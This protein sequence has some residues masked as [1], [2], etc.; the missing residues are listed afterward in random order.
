[1]FLADERTLETLDFFAVRDRVV[2]NTRTERGSVRAGELLPLVDFARVREEQ[3]ATAQVRQ[4]LA[5]ADFF[6]E[7]AID[8][9]VLTA[10]AQQGSALGASDLRAVADALISAMSAYRRVRENTHDVLEKVTAGFV[11]LLQL[12]NA[13][14]DAIDEGAQIL[15]RA[16][17]ALRRLR[18]D[19]VAAQNEAR[20]RVNSMLRS[21]K[22]ERA[23]QESVVTIRE[24]RFVIPIKAEFIGEVPGIVHDSSSSGQTLFVEPLDSVQTNNRLRTLR[25]EEEREVARIL[26]ELS[27]AIGDHAAQIEGNIDVLASLDVLVAKARI[28]QSMNAMAPSLLEKATLDIR[29]GTHPLL[30]QRAVPQSLLLSEEIRL[31][32]VSGPNMGGKTVALKMVGLFVCMTYAGL[33]I[34]ANSGTHIGQ[35]ARVITD[36]G[37]EQSIAQNASTFSAHLLRMAG[38]LKDADAHS[39][40]LVDEIGGGTEPSSGAALAV[41]MLER[42]LQSGACAI[43][44]THVTELKLF[45]HKRDRV[46]NASVRFDPATFAPTY[47]LDV[48][49]P[50]QSLAF[51]LARALG[52]DPRILRR[53]EELLS[54]RERDY[55]H[56]LSELSRLNASAAQERAALQT[57]RSHV[58]RLQDNLRKRVETLENERRDFGRQAEERLRK[59]LGDFSTELARRT[60]STTARPKVTNA[61][62]TLLTRVRDQLHRDLGVKPQLSTDVAPESNFQPDDQVYVISLG[63]EATVLADNGNSILVSVGAMRTT[64]ERADLRRTQRPLQKTRGSTEAGAAALAAATNAVMELDVRGKRFVEAQPLVENWIDE[65]VLS[66]HSPLR[67]IHGKGTGLLGRGLQEY[68]RAHPSVDTVRYGYDNEGGSGVTVFELR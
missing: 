2:A 8:T 12:Q 30:G 45:A 36:I 5:S 4:L 64:V 57:E 58:T 33:Q 22:Y 65:A 19:L 68:L 55:E 27:R 20:E 44:T 28:A 56:A 40:V 13:I 32:V 52:I 53:A 7:G 16:S 26:R 6:V 61:Q 62:S 46:A 17:P 43:V 14:T 49:S 29:E 47:H 34:P 48:G 35:F 41:A 21:A 37:D 54:T 23:I 1:M 59:A 18:R 67:L 60:Q 24:G 39:L 9:A 51:P 10:A 11:P 66:D 63:Q 31:I 25:M 38:I 15:D 3:A 42:L 50:G